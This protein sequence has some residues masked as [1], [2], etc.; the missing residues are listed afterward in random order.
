M[1]PTNLGP[2]LPM[3]KNMLKVLCLKPQ[4]I[5]VILECGYGMHVWIVNKYIIIYI[6]IC[7][8]W[9]AFYYYYYYYMP[10]LCV[11]STARLGLHAVTTKGSSPGIIG[12]QWRVFEAASLSQLHVCEVCVCVCVCVCA[13]AC[14]CVYV[15]VSVCMPPLGSQKGVDDFGHGACGR[16]P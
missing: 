13:R 7:Q 14:V 8:E 4:D 1:P 5:L 9:Q 10:R 6:C 11:R 2:W 16:S 15:C 12:T 3:T